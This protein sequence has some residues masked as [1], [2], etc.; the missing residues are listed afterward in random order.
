MILKE[1]IDFL[2]LLKAN[3]DRQWF[4]NN[5]D[6]F[7][8]TK[9][10]IDSFFNEIGNELRKV[11]SIENIKIYRIYKDI[12]FSKDKTPYK[13]HFSVS[14]SRTKPQLR[15]GYYLQIGAEES[16]IAGGF[17]EPNKED[18]E[19]IRREFEI[20]STEIRT[21]INSSSFK[22]NFG[23]LIGDE[24]KSAPKGFDKNHENID[25]I[26]KKQYLVIRRFNNDEILNESFKNEV[27]NSFR[28][29]RPFFDYMS[30]V[31]VTNLNGESLY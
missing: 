31:L 4:S 8:K 7:Y 6:S 29:M 11:D 20:D 27:I 30:E 2:K 24:L 17:W 23:S 21:I 16:F 22:K 15:G 13:T 5:K 25:L 28:A 1:N 3:N 12:R 14:F 9:Q 10:N 18:L 26:R 19:R